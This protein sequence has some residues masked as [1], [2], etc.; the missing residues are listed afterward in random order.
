MD[1]R[2]GMLWYFVNGAME[3]SWFLGWA[4]FCSLMTM[5]RPFPFFETLLAFAL[6]VFATRISTGKG[7]R[8]ASVIGIELLGFMCGGLLLIHGIYYRSYPLLDSAWLS[9][10]FNGSRGVLEGLILSLNLFLLIIL[11]AGGVTLARRPQTYFNTC[12]RF[13]LGLAAFFALFILKLMALTKGETLAED[14]LSLLFV[15][16]FF[17]S[18]LL[19][20]GM[21][22]TRNYASKAFLPGYRALGF[23]ASFVVVALLGASVLLLF[24]I[25]GLTAA[26]Q[27]GYNT[28]AAAGSPLL[29]LLITILRFLFG[30]RGSHLAVDATKSSPNTASN[31]LTPPVHG[32][33]VELLEK[34]LAWGLWGLLLLTMIIASA[35]ALFY[36]VK[37]LLARTEGGDR[38]KTISLSSRFALLWSFLVG[39]CRKIFR[40]ARGYQKAAE[41]YGAL[42][43]WAQRGGFPH[44]RHETPL[45]FGV[46]L[47]ARFPALKEPI[48]AIIAAYN[49]EVYGEA[50]LN[51]AQLAAANSAWRFLRSPLRWPTRCKGWL[52]GAPPTSCQ[53]VP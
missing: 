6:A 28:L 33:L 5:H 11:W 31:Q 39:T 25:P 53:R 13:D 15:F 50:R 17:L 23:I 36:A 26:A 3:L 8:I 30:P 27:L 9:L 19:A 45:E 40:S 2:K 14:T 38:P 32:W 18:G 37:W 24:F 43:R 34:I 35:I 49:R 22:R 51:Q 1:V 44:G 12:N 7:W 21:A 42:L 52:A 16:P 47:H 29:S 10:F 4:M 41:L 48:E 20:L 46:R